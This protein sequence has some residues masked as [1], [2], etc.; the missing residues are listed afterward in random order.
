MHGTGMDSF[1]E[2]EDRLTSDETGYIVEE[3][4]RI[5]LRITKG[6]VPGVHL[7]E[8]VQKYYDFE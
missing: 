6:E 2:D 8:I 1:D 4:G 3:V 5:A 7:T